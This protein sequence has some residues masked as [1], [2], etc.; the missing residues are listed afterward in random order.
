MLCSLIKVTAASCPVQAIAFRYLSSVAIPNAM[1]IEQE[2]IKQANESY[3]GIVEV[4]VSRDRG[5]GIYASRNL[6]KSERLIKITPLSISDSPNQHSIQIDWDKHIN[7]D[8]PARF[9]NHSCNEANVG[10][11]ILDESADFY[12][13]RDIP[14]GDELLWDYET[15]EYHVSESFPCNCGSSTCRGQIRGFRFHGSQV[16]AAYGPEFIAP[17]LLEKRD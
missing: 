7:V 13:L 1:D 11:K 17:Y 10:I 12:A 14:E 16:L 3:Q 15:S 5:W 9:V 6:L 2:Q 8:I 4:S